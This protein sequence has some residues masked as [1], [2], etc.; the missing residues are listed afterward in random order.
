MKALDHV[1]HA[2]RRIAMPFH[3]TCAADL[4]QSLRAIQRAFGIPLHDTA[5][6]VATLFEAMKESARRSW[7]WNRTQDQWR[8]V[9]EPPALSSQWSPFLSRRGRRRQAGSPSWARVKR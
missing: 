8:Q 2:L 1:I 5:R 9:M 6:E 4:T 3:S 7:L